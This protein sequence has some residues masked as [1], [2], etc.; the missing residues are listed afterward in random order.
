MANP[1]RKDAGLSREALFVSISVDPETSNVTVETNIHN[2]AVM[3]R[4]L[5][6]ASHVWADDHMRKALDAS[7][8]RVHVPSLVPP[9]KM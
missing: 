8:R 6:Q 1:T 5:G 4:V 2:A 3:L 9:R 7:Q